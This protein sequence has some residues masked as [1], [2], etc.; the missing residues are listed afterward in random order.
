MNKP[1]KI[2]IMIPTKYS[3]TTDMKNPIMI[4]VRNQITSEHEL[5]LNI[6][7]NLNFF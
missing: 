2:D 1:S 5:E 4:P 7:A 3:I 6:L